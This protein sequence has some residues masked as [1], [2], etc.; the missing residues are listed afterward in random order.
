M[1]SID[2]NKIPLEER[3]LFIEARKRVQALQSADSQETKAIGTKGV[4][5]DGGVT[6]SFINTG[7]VKI[8]YQQYRIPAGNGDLDEKEFEQ[9]L[10]DYLNWVITHYN[11]ARL[12]GV[13]GEVF[14]KTLNENKYPP[15]RELSDVYV[16]LN[17]QRFSPPM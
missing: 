8:F 14:G 15:T 17:F 3:I 2:L 5:T 4:N 6:D 13:G 10:K 1:E 11:K 12:Y 9:V 7:T 16:P